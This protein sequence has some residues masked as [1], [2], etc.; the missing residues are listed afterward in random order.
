[1]A[2]CR[3]PVGGSAGRLVERRS[4]EGVRDRVAGGAGGQ[5]TAANP[6]AR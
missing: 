3:W 6:P 5:Y 1:M 2:Q 4:E